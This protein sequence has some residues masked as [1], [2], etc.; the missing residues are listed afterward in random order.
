M[1]DNDL[2]TQP[3]LITVSDNGEPSLSATMSMDVV[4]LRVWMIKTSFREVPV[5][6]ESFSDLNLYLLI[7]IVSVSVIFLLS[8]VGLIAGK[9]YRTDSSFS[10]YSAPVISTHP[11]GSWSFSKS[12]QQYDVCFSS[13]R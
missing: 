12:T 4:L 2:K 1:S 10:R 5:K 11:D 7:A 13:T 8:L 3:L 9:C 6:E